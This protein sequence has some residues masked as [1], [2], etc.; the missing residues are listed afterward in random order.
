MHIAQFGIPGGILPFGG[1]IFRALRNL[2]GG[3][4]MRFLL[5]AEE[6]GA[7]ET[8][9]IGLVQEVVPAGQRLDRAVAIACPVAARER[10][11]AY[12]RRWNVILVVP[13]G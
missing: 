4:A 6:S 10:P 5:T 3:N 7:A 8:L 13:S 11:P 1:A 2:A 12:P 9:R